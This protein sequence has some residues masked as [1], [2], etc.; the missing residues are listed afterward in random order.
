MPNTRNS[1]SHFGNI[2]SK[3]IKRSRFYRPC[4]HETTMNA[5]DLVP[6]YRDEVLPGDTVQIKE[7]EVIRMTTPITPVM[8]NAWIDTYYFF[9][10]QRLVWDHWEEFMGENKTDAWTQKVEYTMPKTEAPEGGW[11]KG[12][13][14]SYLGARMYTDDIWIDSCW[15]RAYALIYN[16]WFRNENLVEPAE[17][18]KGDATTTGSNGTDTVTDIQKGGMCA[19][20]MKYAD[21]FTRALPEPQKGPDVYLPLGNTAPV[22]T[23]DGYIPQAAQERITQPTHWNVLANH[24]TATGKTYIGQ[25]SGFS[26][27]VSSFETEGPGMYISNMFADLQNATSATINQLRQAFAVQRL[28]EISARSGSRYIE[29]ILGHFGV[30]SA[31]SRL[32]RPEYLGGKRVPINMTDVVQTSATDAVTP[33]GNNAGMSK[34][35]DNHELFTQSFTEH[36][37]IIG[38]A[39]IRTEHTYQQGIDRM[40]TRQTPLDFY[41]PSLSNLGETYIKNREIFAQGT[42]EDEE[43]FGYQEAWAEYRY[44]TNR[45]TGELNS[46][47]TTPLDIWHYGD[48]YE[49]LPTLGTE[50]IEETD[51]NIARTLA[52]QNQDQFKCDFYFDQTWTRPMPIYSIPG[53]TSWF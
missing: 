35:I 6:I 48:D 8:D 32:Q 19:K 51:Q 29:T 4:R 27:G 22:I 16:E 30:Q 2:P 11:Q 52:I 53:L 23:A 20:V 25:A 1:E 10:P 45:I 37:M 34:T 18:S 41:W 49:A 24:Q 36:G 7:A 33:Q 42:S 44:A 13:I 28:Y 15:L 17:I 26:E 40:L 47:Y 31:D 9:V 21:Y 5:G 43:A 38:L 3:D 12:T 39:C 14:A 46:D 50:W